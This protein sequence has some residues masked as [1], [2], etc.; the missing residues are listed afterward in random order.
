MTKIAKFLNL[1]SET[2]YNLP[3][4]GGPERYK[5]V[6]QTIARDFERMNDPEKRSSHDKYE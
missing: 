5:Q 6:R 3:N 2:C 1:F 4:L